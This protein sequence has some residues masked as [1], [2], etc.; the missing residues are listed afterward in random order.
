MYD[1]S[2]C[3]TTRR[4]SMSM[5]AELALSLGPLH[6][7]IGNLS[8]EIRELRR[9][10]R[11]IQV[12]MPVSATG[13]CPTPTATFALDLGHP[14]QGKWWQVRNYIVGGT[15]IT[16][17]PAGTAWL[18][19]MAGAPSINAPLFAVR[20]ISVGTAGAP[21]ALPYQQNYDAHGIVV[22][23]GE[24]LWTIITGGTAGVQYSATCTVEVF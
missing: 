23:P 1:P 17:A 6:I 24:H 7:A 12:D 3:T 8:D 21:F 11:Q 4:C 10:L 16:Q 14:N 5:E 13:V 19:V 2:I 9:N 22:E 20:D 18:L 15:D